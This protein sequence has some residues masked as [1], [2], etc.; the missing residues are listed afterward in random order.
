MAYFQDV[1]RFLLRTCVAIHLDKD[2][3]KLFLLA[4]MA[5][6]LLALVKGECA[7]ESPDNPQFQE[8]AVS[9]HI[10]LLIIR[11]RLENILGAARRK[12]EFE[13]KRKAD[14]FHLTRFC[15]TFFVKVRSVKDPQTVLSMFFF[16]TS[17]MIKQSQFGLFYVTAMNSSVRLVLRDQGK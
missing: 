11:E 15:I 2:E 14:N 13:A 17:F 6:K 3:D 5:Q 10:L 4:Y 8:A 1:G 12:I 16:F 7:S 9:G